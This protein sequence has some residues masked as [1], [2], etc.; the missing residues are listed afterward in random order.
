MSRVDAR[1][2]WVP[3]LANW[4]PGVTP[5]LMDDMTCSQIIAMYRFI[6][7]NSNG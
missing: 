1:E 4:F 3:A 5:P 6:N 2:L 7:D